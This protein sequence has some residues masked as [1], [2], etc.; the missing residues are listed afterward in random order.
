M[1]NSIVFILAGIIGLL[2]IGIL[3]GAI[4]LILK[5]LHAQDDQILDLRNQRDKVHAE[6]ITL[7]G[8]M[9]TLQDNLT[10]IQQELDALKSRRRHTGPTMACIDDTIGAILNVVTNMGYEKT[11]LDAALNYLQTMRQGPYAYESKPT[12]EREEYQ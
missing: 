10:L 1:D 12:G 5:L 6:N 2:V 8:Q 3:A 9:V 7:N 11:R 4:L